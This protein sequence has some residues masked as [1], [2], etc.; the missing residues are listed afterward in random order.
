[1][2]AKEK[3]DLIVWKAEEDGLVVTGR[4]SVTGNG[5][6]ENV[7]LDPEGNRIEIIS[8]C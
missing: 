2:L 6:Y 7:I 3:V 8:I 5:Y 1:L 4:P